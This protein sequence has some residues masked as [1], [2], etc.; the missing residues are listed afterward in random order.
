MKNKQKKNTSLAVVLCLLTT[1][2]AAALPFLMPGAE[3]HV[4]PSASPGGSRQIY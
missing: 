2:F 3:A 4:D 1:Y